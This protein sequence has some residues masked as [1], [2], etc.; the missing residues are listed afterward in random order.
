MVGELGQGEP[1][2]RVLLVNLYMGYIGG[3]SPEGREVKAGAFRESYMLYLYVLKKGPCA[4]QGPCAAVELEASRTIKNITYR[5]RSFT[6]SPLGNNGVPVEFRITPFVLRDRIS[7]GTVLPQNCALMVRTR[8]KHSP[9]LLIVRGKIS[10]DGQSR[11][12]LSHDTCALQDRYYC[13]LSV[14]RL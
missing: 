1:E 3:Y 8:K 9:Q 11:G 7:D 6:L 5:G 14:E 2:G 13:T 10:C 4:A 12:I